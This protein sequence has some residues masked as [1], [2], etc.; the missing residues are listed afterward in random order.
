[1]IRKKL[2]LGLVVILLAVS[3][4][5]DPA[6]S[7]DQPQP[8]LLAFKSLESISADATRDDIAAFAKKQF[9]NHPQ[10]DDWTQFCFKLRRSGRGRISTLKG[11]AELHIH[12]LTDVDAEKHAEEILAYT[13]ALQEIEKLSQMLAKNGAPLASSYFSLP[14]SEI[15]ARLPK[16]TSPGIT[17]RLPYGASKVAAVDKWEKAALKHLV[18]FNILKEKDTYAAR[19][20]LL[21]IAKIR[22]GAHS[23]ADE[24][25]PL[26]FRLTRDGK[27]RISDM[28]R[29]AELEIRMLT[30][31]DAEKHAEQIQRHQQS[32]E[33]YDKQIQTL[34]SEGKNPET[35]TVKFY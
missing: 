21:E 22:F 8:I 2:T 5:I 35:L 17:Y 29:F 24:W 6:G 12:M 9:G 20:K 4:G 7:E 26:Y 16:K 33:T 13:G 34:K 27:G 3:F 10:I 19:S 28:K 31:I 18:Q 11:F 23:L 25:I 30:D 32:I 14:F 15:V 1:M